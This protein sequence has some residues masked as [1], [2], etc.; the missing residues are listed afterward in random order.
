MPNNEVPGNCVIVIIIH[1][2]GKY[3][4]FEYLGIAAYSYREQKL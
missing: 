1:V 4:I 2:L 3:M